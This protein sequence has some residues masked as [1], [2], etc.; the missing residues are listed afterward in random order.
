M[1]DPLH[2]VCPHC[3][4]INRVPQ[5]RLRQGGK[6]GVCH[7][8]LFDG[9][10]VALDDVAR[11]DKHTARSD[12]PVLVDAWAAWCGP[13]RMMAPIFQEAAP[14]LEPSVRLAKVDSDKVPEVLQRYGIQSIPTLLLLHHG[15][16]I[17]R[18]TGVMALPQLVA[19]TKRHADSVAA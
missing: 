6:C 17:G 15:R 3:D 18:S 7:R 1:T 11:F 12:I 19:W 4:A 5:E 13:C 2:I 9:H 8:P 16:G 14:A 10:P